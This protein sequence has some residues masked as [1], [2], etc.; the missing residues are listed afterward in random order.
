MPRIVSRNGQQFREISAGRSAESSVTPADLT[1]TDFTEAAYWAST[2]LGLCH[3][4]LPFIDGVTSKAFL[5]PPE[6]SIPPAARECCVDGT[7]PAGSAYL[8]LVGCRCGLA[9]RIDE[10]FGQAE[11]DGRL[12]RWLAPVSQ[13]FRSNVVRPRGHVH[14]AAKEPRSASKSAVAVGVI[15]GGTFGVAVA[16]FVVVRMR[17]RRRSGGTTSGKYRKVE[18]QGCNLTDADADET[19]ADAD[20]MSADKDIQLGERAKAAA[21]ED[22]VFTANV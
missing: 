12:Q 6:P 11:A 21:R 22:I 2:D 7:M 13:Q 16:A 17:W 5:L 15:V 20:L 18:E 8:P 19:I 10:F 3:S 14:R 4:G 9:G 1:I